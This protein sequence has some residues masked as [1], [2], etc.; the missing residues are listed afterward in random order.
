MNKQLEQQKKVNREKMQRIEFLHG[1]P[2]ELPPYAKEDLDLITTDT[3][4]KAVES[5]REIIKEMVQ[6]INGNMYFNHEKLRAYI[7]ESHLKT[8]DNK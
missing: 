4:N 2:V 3:W 8:P 5:E 7:K 6:E 1:V